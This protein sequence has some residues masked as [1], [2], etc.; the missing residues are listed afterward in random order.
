MVLIL[1]TTIVMVVSSLLV[2]DDS[3]LTSNAPALRESGLGDPA[4]AFPG[5][6]AFAV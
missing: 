6:V 5:A 2:A 3:T 4:L 1:I